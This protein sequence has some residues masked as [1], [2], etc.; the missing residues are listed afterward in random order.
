M[1]CIRMKMV[2]YAEKLEL[3]KEYRDGLIIKDIFTRTKSLGYHPMI[4]DG[5]VTKYFIW[6]RTNF[7]DKEIQDVIDKMIADDL[8]SM[9]ELPRPY[10]RDC[11]IFRVR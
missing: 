4:E 7:S 5:K 3:L 8:D 2:G 6:S 11:V 9:E 10:S 1:R